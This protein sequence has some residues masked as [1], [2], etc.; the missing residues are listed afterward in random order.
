M[1]KMGRIG[2]L[3]PIHHWHS[4]GRVL[5]GPVWAETHVFCTNFLFAIQVN[6]A[7]QDPSTRSVYLK[8]SFHW[9]SLALP[10][11]SVTTRFHFWQELLHQLQKPNDPAVWHMVW[12]SRS[13][14]HV[15]A[16]PSNLIVPLTLL[17]IT[18][19]PVSGDVHPTSL[20]SK[21]AAIWYWSKSMW[22]SFFFCLRAFFPI[23][24]SVSSPVCTVRWSY[25]GETALPWLS[26]FATSWR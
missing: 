23:S 15:H 19:L 7:T 14:T 24:M 9:S 16:N 10:S 11:S 18:F 21:K 17:Q 5:G 12:R 20:K 13:L 3:H 2:I 4:K 26:R 6:I 22:I 25:S 1:V 8:T